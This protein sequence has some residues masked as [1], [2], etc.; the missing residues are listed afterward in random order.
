MGQY[1]KRKCLLALYDSI[2]NIAWNSSSPL[3]TVMNVKEMHQVRI[4]C[5]RRISKRCSS[6]PTKR[7]VAFESPQSQ[8]SPND[9]GLIVSAK[10]LYG[11]EGRKRGRGG[12]NLSARHKRDTGRG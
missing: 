10:K 11:R 12:Q 3:S 1:I 8:C 2:S 5:G 6:W 9:L 4:G 7:M